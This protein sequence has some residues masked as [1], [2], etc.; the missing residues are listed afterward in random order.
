LERV[1]QDGAQNGFDFVR[2]NKEFIN[3]AED[4]AGP[5]EVYKKSGFT[6]HY[7]IDQKF[8]MRKYL[9]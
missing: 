2:H 5:V 9:K 6:V 8:V 3:E 1:C 4:F 7:E